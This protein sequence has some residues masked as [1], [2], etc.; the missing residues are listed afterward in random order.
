MSELDFKKAI[1]F[2]SNSD[3]KFNYFLC[4]T[5]IMIGLYFMIKFIVDYEEFKNKE[6]LMTIILPLVFAFY[7]LWRIPKDYIVSAISSRKPI[8]EKESIINSY[9]TTSKLKVIW[10]NKNENVI[11]IR[12]RNYYFNKVDLKVYIDNEKFLFNAQGTDITGAK[13]IWDFG[14]TNRANQKIKNFLLENS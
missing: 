11:D 2:S 4:A 13:G 3:N 8:N 1:T 9:F 5:L 14:L 6:S 10:S 7:G 12:Y